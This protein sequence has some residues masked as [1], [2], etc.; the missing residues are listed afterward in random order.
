MDNQTEKLMLQ[1][2][3]DVLYVEDDERYAQQ[4][5]AYMEKLGLRVLWCQTYT[6][7]VQA[8]TSVATR[9][10]VADYDLGPLSPG[11]NGLDVLAQYNGRKILFS[12]ACPDSTPEDVEVFDKLDLFKL[13][14][15]LTP[16]P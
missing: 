16:Q 15:A 2:S 12:G 6:A 9:V 13:F 10:C 4:I 1:D 7:A 8:N 3:L 11:R 14:E 5:V